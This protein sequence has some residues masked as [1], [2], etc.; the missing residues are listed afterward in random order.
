MEPGIEPEALVLSYEASILCHNGR[1]ERYRLKGAIV[2]HIDECIQQGDSRPLT[3]P[4]QKKEG[5]PSFVIIQS[6]LK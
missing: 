4:P 2:L 6:G 3:L 1:L 5:F